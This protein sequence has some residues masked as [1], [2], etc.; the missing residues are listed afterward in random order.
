MIIRSQWIALPKLVLR[1]KGFPLQNMNSW[2]VR[3]TLDHEVSSCQEEED[4]SA[5]VDP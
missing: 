5:P 1:D 4:P 2:T 3:L